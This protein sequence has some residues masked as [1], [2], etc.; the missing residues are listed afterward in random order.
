MKTNKCGRSYRPGVVAHLNGQRFGALVVTGRAPNDERGSAMWHCK[1]D[2]GGEGVFPGGR[3]RQNKRTYCLA[4]I[5]KIRPKPLTAEYRSEYQ[6][7]TNM[8]AR[9]LDPTN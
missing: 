6:S 3:L 1:C 9:C 4:P 2:C 8:R 7:W 5:H